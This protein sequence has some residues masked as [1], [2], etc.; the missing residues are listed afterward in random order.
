MRT[1]SII[2]LMAMLALVIDLPI[3]GLGLILVAVVLLV[4]DLVQ[5][6]PET[7]CNH[8]CNQGNDCT[9]QSTVQEPKEEPTK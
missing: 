1:V 3:A 5:C 9:C 4:G 6:L 7:R 8:N 2:L